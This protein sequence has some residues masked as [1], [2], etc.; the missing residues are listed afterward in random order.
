MTTDR[1]P[2]TVALKKLVVILA[3]VV[4]L[5]GFGLWAVLYATGN[6]M[7]RQYTSYLQSGTQVYF[8]ENEAGQGLYAARVTAYVAG[9]QILF[10][11]QR[12]VRG[13]TLPDVNETNQYPVVAAAAIPFKRGM[14]YG[15]S[16]N[17]IYQSKIIP[18]L[19]LNPAEGGFDEQQ[20]LPVRTV[21][22]NVS[23]YAGKNHFLK[24]ASHV[25][26]HAGQFGELRGSTACLTIDPQQANLFF[27]SE[28]GQNG[29]LHIKR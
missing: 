2:E 5:L 13:S 16:T 6:S 11:D 17:N 8:D 10:G 28:I 24:H 9:R 12:F 4:V 15:S 22:E 1:Q 14:H 3:V 19:I 27:E 25:H 18:A 21:G 23:P 7:A 20:G 26:V 29:T